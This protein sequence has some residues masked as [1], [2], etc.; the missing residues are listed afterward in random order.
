MAKRKVDYKRKHYIETKGEGITSV[1]IVKGDDAGY[2]KQIK[3]KCYGSTYMPEAQGNEQIRIDYYDGRCT[4]RI[5]GKLLLET[6]LILLDDLRNTL[7][8]LAKDDP[9]YFSQVRIAVT[10]KLKP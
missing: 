9:F 2:W 10:K 3:T 8:V 5:E 6:N 7:N 4:V 1:A